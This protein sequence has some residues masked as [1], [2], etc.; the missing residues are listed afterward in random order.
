MDKS[1]FRFNVRIKDKEF[2]ISIAENAQ[3]IYQCL[4]L[5]SQFFKKVNHEGILD[6]DIYDNSCCHLLVQEI[7]SQQIAGVYRLIRYDVAKKHAGFYSETEFNLE[8]IRKLNFLEVS[9]LCVAPQY[10]SYRIVELLWSGIYIYLDYHQLDYMG[11]C[12]SIPSDKKYSSS[13]IY[14]YARK[15]QLLVEKEFEVLPQS[16]TRDTSLQKDYI[17]LETQDAKSILPKLLRLYFH[18]GLKVCGPSAYDKELN[19]IDFFCIGNFKNRHHDPRYK[20][21]LNL[22]PQDQLS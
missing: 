15:A 21:I 16:D 12:V 6:Q 2:M 19:L 1:P 8:L 4:A 17:L 18:F 20:R 7:K 22:I 9:R 3:E 13:E 5:R 14:A 10:K 11:G